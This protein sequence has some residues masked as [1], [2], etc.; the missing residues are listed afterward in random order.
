MKSLFR[1]GSGSLRDQCKAG[2]LALLLA[3]NGCVAGAVLFGGAAALVINEGFIA[4][5]TY[6]GVIKSTPGKAYQAAI[7]VM[8]ELCHRIVLEKAFRMVT[9]TWR[10]VDVEVSIEDLGAGEV[11]L[12]VKARK[13][14]LA[15]KDSAV[16]IFQMIAE[17]IRGY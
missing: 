3:L 12:R 13:Y 11:K 5:D 10:N 2:V 9:G 7:N 15:D 14:M 17:R 8:D 4:E 16:D 6:A 1:L